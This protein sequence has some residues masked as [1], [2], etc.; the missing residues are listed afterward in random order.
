MYSH[1]L[2]TRPHVNSLCEKVQEKEVVSRVK[3]FP[4]PNVI[5]ILS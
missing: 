3:V 4:K 5:S 2:E 1:Y